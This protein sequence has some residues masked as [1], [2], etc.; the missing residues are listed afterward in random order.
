MNADPLVSILMTV[1][2]REKYIEQAIESVLTS[3]YSNFELIIVDDCSKDRSF[4]IATQY[5][6][7]DQRITVYRNE[8]NIGDYP[9]R[10][11]AAGYAKGKYLKYVDADDMLYYYGLEVMVKF[12][13]LFPEAGFGLGC[14]PDEA[15][16]F[17][18]L[19]SPREIYLES[20]GKVNHF[21]RAPGSGLIKREV[22]NA[23]G[24]FSGKRMIGDYEFWF[25][26]SRYYSMV[27]LPLDLYWNRIHEGQES[28]TDYARKNYDK[29]KK[30]IME[31]SLNHPDCPLSKQEIVKVKKIIRDQQIKLNTLILLSRLRRI[32]K[33]TK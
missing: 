17:P 21:D 29:L 20:F 14:Y 13:E 32:V 16:P 15:R 8:K 7:K 31:E 4:E 30:P 23:I 33:K 9:N 22:F 10:N 1:Y 6:R 19:I 5:A 26:I 2:N 28:Q 12:T 25:K 3:T 11:K 24:G 27:K 18:A